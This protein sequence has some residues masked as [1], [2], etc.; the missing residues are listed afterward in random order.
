MTLQQLIALQKASGGQ[1]VITPDNAGRIMGLAAQAEANR[2]LSMDAGRLAVEE[3]KRL[4]QLEAGQTPGVVTAPSGAKFVTDAQGN[5]VGTNAPI[6]VGTGGIGD[7]AAIN[8][9]EATAQEQALIGPAIREAFQLEMQKRAPAPTPVAEAPAKQ[10]P[11]TPAQS[12]AFLQ[13][14][15]PSP[16]KPPTAPPV[17]AAEKAVV[18]AQGVP[19]LRQA[20][21]QQALKSEKESAGTRLSDAERKAK[22]A[23]ARFE[24]GKGAAS[25]EE[26]QALAEEYA[27]AQAEAELLNTPPKEQ[28]AKLAELIKQIR[29]GR[30][31]KMEPKGIFPRIG[32][33]YESGKSYVSDAFQNAIMNPLREAFT[34]ETAKP[35]NEL[36]RYLLQQQLMRQAGF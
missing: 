9:G 20:F 23:L 1:N 22:E 32:F 35:S 34:G 6:G 17:R 7:R 29:Q 10:P 30:T 21:E 2:Q 5:V 3:R 18:S 26:L 33:G 11:M 19:A 12:T 15:A 31:E 25:K 8:R 13:A 27:A 36:Y 16:A 4:Q 24:S 14:T 28:E